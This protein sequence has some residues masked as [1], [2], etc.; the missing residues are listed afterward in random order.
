MMID[1]SEDELILTSGKKLYANCLIVGIDPEL[2]VSG[3]YDQGGLDRL[4]NYD[5]HEYEK[6][7]KE[8]RVELANHMI[9]LWTKYKDQP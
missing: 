4:Y 6:I 5:A 8:D 1:K 2:N 7:G 9:A 3:G